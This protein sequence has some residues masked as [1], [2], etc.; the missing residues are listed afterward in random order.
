MERGIASSV[1]LQAQASPSS[2]KLLGTGVED[3][4][5]GRDLTIF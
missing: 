4:G 1:V 5:G 3:Q 2:N